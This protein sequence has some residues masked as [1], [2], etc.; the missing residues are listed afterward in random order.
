MSYVILTF[1]CIDAL[2]D[3]DPIR[4]AVKWKIALAAVAF[5]VIWFQLLRGDRAAVPWVFALAVVYF[6][7]AS[8]FTQRNKNIKVP[9]FK[10]AA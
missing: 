1:A 4:R 7:W 3:R 2:L 10:L 9:W 6:Y 5:V 8:A